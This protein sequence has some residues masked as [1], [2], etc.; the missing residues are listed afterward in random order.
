MATLAELI[1]LDLVRLPAARIRHTML[2]FETSFNDEY[3]L[4]F[5]KFTMAQLLLLRERL[6]I[7][8]SFCIQKTPDRHIPGITALAILLHRLSKTATTAEIAR[9]FRTSRSTIS[10]AYN[11]MLAFFHEHSAWSTIMRCN[12][13]R[14]TRMLPH[15]AAAIQ[16]TGAHVPNCIGFVD[17]TN[18]ECARPVHGQQDMYSGHKHYHSFKWQSLTTPDGIMSH[19]FG[20]ISGR[21]TDMYMWHKSGVQDLFD[22]EER[23]PYCIWADEGYHS[24]GCLMAP[25]RRLPPSQLSSA[26]EEVNR[27][28][29]FPRLGVEHVF[30]LVT[31]TFTWFRVPYRIKTGQMAIERAYNVAIFFTNIRTCLGYANQVST[32][33][34]MPPP[35]LDEFLTLE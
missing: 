20:P 27:S 17:G 22:A 15:Y 7:P 1:L 31:N 5:F 28:M 9:S 16:R 33:F 3:C 12:V 21:H 4:E 35:T 32:A 18:R 11:A 25:F 2:D 10:R 30:A 23:R 29:L 19:A 34:D 13:S 24:A 26:E 8:N 14:L 6:E